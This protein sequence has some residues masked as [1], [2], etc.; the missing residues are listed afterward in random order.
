MKSVRLS[1]QHTE[2]TIHPMHAFVCESPAVE[3]EVLLEGRTDDGV[4]TLLFYV[5]GDPEAYEAVL[6]GRPDL[7][8][9]DVRSDDD[10]GFFLYVRA[11]NRPEEDLL[12][13][14][15]DRETIVVVPPTEFRADMTMRLTVVGHGEDLRDIVTALPESLSVDILEVGTYDRAVHSTLTERQR[16]AIAAGR[17]VGY[18]EVPREGDIDAVADRLGCAVSTASTLLR[19]AESRLVADALDTQW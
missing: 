8:E 7:L 10:G 3:R 13:E 6:D 5:E 4:R 14:A 9:Y 16:E 17:A 18:Y 1:I 11:E 2:E 12:F 19:R 15:L